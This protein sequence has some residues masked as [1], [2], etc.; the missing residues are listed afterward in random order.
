MRLGRSEVVVVAGAAPHLQI[1][2]ANRL[3]HPISLGFDH[4]HLHSAFVFDCAN[5]NRYSTWVP[6]GYSRSKSSHGT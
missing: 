2:F 3:P 6:L 1:R 4:Q 5:V